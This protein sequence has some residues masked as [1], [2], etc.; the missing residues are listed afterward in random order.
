[1]EKK[2]DEP[3]LVIADKSETKRE[4][5]ILLAVEAAVAMKRTICERVEKLMEDGHWLPSW[6]SAV[7]KLL[8]EVFVTPSM[9]G[10]K[11]NSSNGKRCYLFKLHLPLRSGDNFAMTFSARGSFAEVKYAKEVVEL[12]DQLSITEMKDLPPNLWATIVSA[13][14]DTDQNVY[15]QVE[16]QY[17]FERHLTDC[18]NWIRI[19]PTL[20]H[21][22]VPL[23]VKG[24]KVD[25]YKISN[26][27]E[28]CSSEGEF[29][30]WTKHLV[31]PKSMKWRTGVRLNWNGMLTS[32]RENPRTIAAF[33]QQIMR[34][35]QLCF[36]H[37]SGKCVA[38]Q[39]LCK[40][41]IE[42]AG[43]FHRT[44]P[45]TILFD[46]FDSTSQLGQAVQAEKLHQQYNV[47]QWMWKYT[48][49]TR[50]N[51]VPLFAYE[52]G[53]TLKKSNASISAFLS[54]PLSAS[55]ARE[56]VVAAI[57]TLTHEEVMDI[58]ILLSDIIYNVKKRR[59]TTTNYDTYG[60]MV[61]AVKVAYRIDAYEN[62]L[63]QLML[64]LTP[65]FIGDLANVIGEYSLLSVLPEQLHRKLTSSTSSTGLT[66]CEA[67]WNG[68]DGE[69]Y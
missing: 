49:S 3:N 42:Q 18:P 62:Y 34:I 30:R 57:N 24:K 36:R 13:V 10:S 53:G 16:V 52:V 31:P 14:H 17:A 64:R 9:V 43:K 21:R 11:F 19:P 33:E 22:N 25:V 54:T 55:K 46:L 35:L 45:K 44:K 38:A 20:F 66:A 50:Q 32:F 63:K 37:H 56:V 2:A 1:M 61:A 29:Y 26:D 58:I 5:R 59:E 67:D 39:N 6:K 65:H 60:W 51:M 47:R 23:F 4:R 48:S 28:N 12:R 7:R 40:L 8:K 15:L 69:Y 27:D 68:N 41:V